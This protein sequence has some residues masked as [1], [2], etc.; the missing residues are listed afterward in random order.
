MAIT[1]ALVATGPRRTEMQGHSVF[2]GCGGHPAG[3]GAGPL[4]EEVVLVQRQGSGSTQLTNL[5]RVIR[6]R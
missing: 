5:V 2:F 3:F 4:D 6:I 1:F